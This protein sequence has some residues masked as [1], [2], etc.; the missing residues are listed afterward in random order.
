MFETLEIGRKVKR[1]DFNKAE[2]ELRQKLLDLQFQLE[3]Q[4]FPVIIN[5]GDM[6]NSLYIILSGRVK[7]FLDDESGK[8][9]ILNVVEAGDYFGE[10]SLFDDGKRSACFQLAMILIATEPD[11]ALSFL[12][13]GCGPD[14][15]AARRLAPESA[16]RL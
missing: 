6:T 3:E 11:R 14:G 15:L 2:L 5:E 8:E 7:V 13:R 10:V 4:D 12:R 9:V 16:G 1:K